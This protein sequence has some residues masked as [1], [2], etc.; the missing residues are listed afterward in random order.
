M[1][2]E[3]RASQKED[4]RGEEDRKNEGVDKEG[5]GEKDGGEEIRSKQV[6]YN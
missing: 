5:G 4:G 3:A 2:E 6:A 1:R